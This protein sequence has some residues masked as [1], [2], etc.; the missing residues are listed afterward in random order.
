MIWY[1]INDGNEYAR[2]IFHRHYS[3]RPYR[4]DRRPKLF[5]G[6]GEKMV[7]V[8]KNCDAIFVCRKFANRNNQQGIN[9]AIFRN[10][11]DTLSSLLI[12]EAEEMAWKKWEPQRLYTYINSRRIK[13][14]NPGYCFLKAG[15]RRCGITKVNKLIILEKTYEEKQETENKIIEEYKKMFLPGLLR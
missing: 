3:Y 4:D 15:W 10:E 2:K 11:S 5:V 1:I 9:C 7:L 8:T 13:S 14:S 12:L 6:P